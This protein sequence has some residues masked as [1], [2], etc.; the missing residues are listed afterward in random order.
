MTNKN[1]IEALLVERDGYAR[2]NLTERV[3]AID[4]TLR[5]LGYVAK[6]TAALD[7]GTER[8]TPPKARKR[9]K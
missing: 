1:L 5:D 9:K 7:P 8:A 4:A 3:E 6:E 2:R